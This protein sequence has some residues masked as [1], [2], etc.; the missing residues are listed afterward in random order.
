ML[1]QREKTSSFWLQTEIC[2]TL[3]GRY[4]SG[5]N[6]L[7]S[8]PFL[9]RYT[10]MLARLTLA[11]TASPT[12][13]CDVTT[14]TLIMLW[15]SSILRAQGW[16]TAGVKR[17]KGPRKRDGKWRT[18]CGSRDGAT[19]RM[20]W[21]SCRNSKSGFGV[22][23]RRS[24]RFLGGAANQCRYG[25]GCARKG[26]GP[27]TRSSLRI[28]SWLWKPRSASSG[29]H[30]LQR[31]TLT[32]RK[33]SAYETA[34]TALSVGL[35]KPSATG[36]PRLSLLSDLPS[37]RHACTEMPE[38]VPSLQWASDKDTVGVLCNSAFAFSASRGGRKE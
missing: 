12:T 5:I 18:G 6:P 2:N 23:P 36:F 35:F 22:I 4:S 15:W 8:G 26:S 14:V 21:L 10:R 24:I 1:R 37:R 13:S 11:V 38:N 3:S 9:F 30:G 31:S 20:S 32:S 28:R 7:G 25:N 27:K 33:R 29:A 17:L 19:E 16:N 34:V